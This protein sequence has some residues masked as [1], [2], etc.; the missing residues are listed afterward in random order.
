MIIE[1]TQTPRP[2]RFLWVLQRSL[3]HK[4][5]SGLTVGVRGVRNQPDSKIMLRRKLVDVAL[6]WQSRFGIAP[7]VTTP[8]SEYDAA[9]LVGMSEEECSLFMQD[10]T[11]VMKGCDFIYRGVRY[12]VKANRPS[13][14]PGSK[15]T[16][17]PKAVNYNWDKLIWVLYDKHYVM[18]EAWEWDVKA[19][20]EAFHSLKRLSPSHYRKGRC[21]Y[22][23]HL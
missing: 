14:K 20:K 22:L 6:E 19:Y 23:S 10:K 16:L 8:I 12:Q 4:N 11:A 7:Q 15:V 5:Y 21:L 3:S 9:T 1:P 13:G 17:V 2:A 18:Q